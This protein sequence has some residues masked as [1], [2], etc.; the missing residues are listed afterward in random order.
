VGSGCQRP[1]VGLIGWA[2]WWRA[3]EGSGSERLDLHWTVAIRT[4][5]IKPRPPDLRWTSEIQRSTTGLGC[6]GAA[7]PRGKVSPETRGT[8]TTRL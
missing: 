7:R 6:G 1:E 3:G 2:Q 8:A 5:M 4:V